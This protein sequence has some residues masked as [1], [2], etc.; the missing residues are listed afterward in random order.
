MIV[1]YGI[2]LNLRKFEVN[3]DQKIIAFYFEKVK[4]LQKRVFGRHPLFL[5]NPSAKDITIFAFFRDPGILCMEKGV[6]RTFSFFRFWKFC[7]F[8]S[9][10]LFLLFS[11]FFLFFLFSTFFYFFYFSLFPLF[12]KKT[13]QFTS[14]TRFSRW[15]EKKW[16]GRRIREK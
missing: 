8:V 4:K 12:T 3:Q 13:T 9:I 7:F 2:S 15:G 1:R 14:L 16:V 5:Q 6:K 11:T 10:R